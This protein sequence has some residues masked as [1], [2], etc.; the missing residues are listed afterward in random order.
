MAVEKEMVAT[1]W[2]SV[3]MSARDNVN[4]NAFTIALINLMFH[5]LL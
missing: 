5:F 3:Q 2:K 4:L 1:R